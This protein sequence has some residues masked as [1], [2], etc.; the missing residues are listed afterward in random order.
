MRCDQRR[1]FL[2][3]LVH[4]LQAK[5]MDDQEMFSR[6]VPAALTET[7]ARWYRLSGELQRIPRGIPP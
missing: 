1:D 3:L 2:D 4:Y 6:I 7:A 5:G